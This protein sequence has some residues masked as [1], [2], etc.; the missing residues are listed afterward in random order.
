MQT[1]QFYKCRK[2]LYEMVVKLKEKKLE[3]EYILAFCYFFLGSSF[4]DSRPRT[5]SW[6]MIRALGRQSAQRRRGCS[7]P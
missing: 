5:R 1:Q 2:I 7:S 3:N 6:L 4:D